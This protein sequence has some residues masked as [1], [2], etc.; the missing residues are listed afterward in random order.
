VVTVVKK[1]FDATQPH[2]SYF[3]Q[4]D[5]QQCVV[6]QN[7]V[8]DLGLPVEVVVCPIVREPDGLAMSS[9]N[10]YLNEDER[11][12]A[13]VLQHSLTRAREL[14]EAGERDAGKLAAV[15]RTVLDAE[16]LAKIDYAAVVDAATFQPVER[17]T[18]PAIIPLA[19]WIGRARL[20][21]NLRVDYADGHFSFHL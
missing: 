18:G 5:A 17:I 8:R 14:L 10:A 6:I 7:M 1:L 16:P 11:K 21:D 15:V 12:A 20:L 13:L 2:R 19:V 4:K 3:G 9:R